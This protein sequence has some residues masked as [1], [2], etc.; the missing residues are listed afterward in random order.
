ME[1]SGGREVFNARP[2]GSQCPIY[3]LFP[4]A[5]INKMTHSLLTLAVHSQRSIGGAVPGHAG[6]VCSR[7]PAKAQ[8]QN[9]NLAHGYCCCLILLYFFYYLISIVF[10]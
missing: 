10:F 4:E 7:P 9:S 2:P 3:M 5:Q 6:T 1:R 8:Q